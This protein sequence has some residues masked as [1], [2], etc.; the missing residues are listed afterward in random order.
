MRLLLVLQR[1]NQKVLYLCLLVLFIS[2]AFI[3]LVKHIYLV[4][5]FVL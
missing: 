2:K 5:I 1:S 4:S 3:F